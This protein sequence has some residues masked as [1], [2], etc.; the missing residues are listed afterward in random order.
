MHKHGHSL[1]EIANIVKHKNLESLKWY[2]E[3]PDQK[4]K[5][6]YCKSLSKYVGS[7]DTL[8]NEDSDISDFE[9]PPAP[10]KKKNM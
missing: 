7:K 10:P 5:E 4:D 2:L 6:N 3:A 9:P 1:Q 8:T